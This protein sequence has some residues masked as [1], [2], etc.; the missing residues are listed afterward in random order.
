MKKQVFH[1]EL[2]RSSWKKDVYEKEVTSKE[3]EK[4]PEKTQLPTVH[5]VELTQSIPC[6]SLIVDIVLLAD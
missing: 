3:G 4:I 5:D 2:P 1:Q 6:Q